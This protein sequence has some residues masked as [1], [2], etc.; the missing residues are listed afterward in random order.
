VITLSD[1]RR[2]IAA[3]EAKA[4]EIDQPMNIA[5]VDGGGN[6]VSHVR[7]DGAWIGSIDISINKAFTA[8]AFDIETEQ[9]AKN[10]QPGQQFFGIHA[11]NHGRVMIF[12]G[13]IPLRRGGA[14]IGAI[15]V[16][17]GDGNQDQTVATAGAAV[18]SN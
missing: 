11:S 15:G 2:V 7:M 10:S 9:L 17:G 1:A 16:S 6:L 3:A 18:F 8:R 13:G 5:V 12:A 14:V 4:H